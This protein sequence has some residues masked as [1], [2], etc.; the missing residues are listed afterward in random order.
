MIAG[1]TDQSNFFPMFCFSLGM[2]SFIW[3]A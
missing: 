2:K 3:A 1:C